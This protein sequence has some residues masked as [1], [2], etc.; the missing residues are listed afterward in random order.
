VAFSPDSKTV[1]SG[2]RD[3]TIRLWDATT[4]EEMQKRETSRVVSRV[5]FSDDGSN[6]LTNIGQLDL[7]LVPV[8]HQATVTK[9]Q[10]IVLIDSSWIEVRGSD[11][12]WLPHEYRGVSYDAFGSRLV[13]GQASG[14]ISFS[15][16]SN[17]AR[18]YSQGKINSRSRTIEFKTGYPA[19][20]PVNMFSSPLDTTSSAQLTFPSR[21]KRTI[22][23]RSFST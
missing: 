6:L 1:A 5:A 21:L 20:C 8:T 19:L 10:A 23:T 16:S 14:A 7:G 9:L 13:V 18:I 11:V 4:G 17:I 22:S 3:K 2:S 15:P 12:L